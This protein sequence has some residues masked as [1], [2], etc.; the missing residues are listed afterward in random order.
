MEEVQEKAAESKN[1]EQQA[2]AEK[3]VIAID[4]QRI[5]IFNFE[6]ADG[7]DGAKPNALAEQLVEKN[8]AVEVD[9]EMSE[10]DPRPEDFAELIDPTQEEDDIE[11]VSQSA[12]LSA[13]NASI[14]SKSSK[15]EQRE[16][17]RKR[18]DENYTERKKKEALQVP[19]RR[20]ILNLRTKK[21]VEI[22]LNA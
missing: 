5:S 18:K 13:S 20:R 22:S 2:A 1:G 19:S 8:D 16:K 6:Q 11:S 4:K 12:S 15:M 9:V 3:L 10:E 14:K 7:G 17:R 21:R